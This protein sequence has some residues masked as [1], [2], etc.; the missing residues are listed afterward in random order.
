[1]AANGASVNLHIDIVGYKSFD[2][3]T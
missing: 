1:L 3:E 2:I